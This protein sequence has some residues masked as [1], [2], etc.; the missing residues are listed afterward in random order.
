[1]MRRLCRNLG[2]RAALAILAVAALSACQK[3]IY[4]SP[5]AQARAVT[6]VR[7]EPRVIEGGLSASGQLIPRLDVAV[8]PELTGY[9]V[10]KLFVDEGSWVKKNQPMAQMDPVLLADVARQQAALAAQQQ[11]LARQAQTQAQRVKGIDN[12]GLLSEEQIQQRRFAARSAT[13][14]YN[15]QEAAAV[16]AKNRLSMATVRAPYAGLVI[17]RNVNP[18]DVS[19]AGATPWFRIARD[20]VIELDAD[21]PEEDIGKIRVGDKAKVTVTG[22]GS[23]IGV[24]RLISPSISTTTHLGKVRITLPVRSDIRSGG[25]AHAVFLEGARAALAV[26]DTAVRYDADGASVMAVGAD[27]RLQRVPVTTGQRGGGFVELV[28]GPPAGTV[29]VAKAA[30]MFTPG[31]FVRIAAAP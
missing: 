3:R 29:V 2:G 24:V 21:V 10:D 23:A 17:E 26:P 8:F 25:F 5:K 11:A 31:D 13:A 4:V 12:A 7:V 30:A 20:G 14:Q 19:A 18:G 22:G 28:A 9:R 6:V 1:M 16:D 27:D 15:A